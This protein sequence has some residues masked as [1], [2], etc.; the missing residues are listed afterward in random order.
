MAKKNKNSAESKNSTESKNR[1]ENE[2]STTTRTNTPPTYNLLEQ[3][4]I[5]VLRCDGSPD[6]IAPHQLTEGLCG[7]RKSPIMRLNSNRADFNAA[8]AQFLIGLYQT[9]FAPETEKEWRYDYQHPPTPDEL[10]KLFEQYK[11]FFWLDGDGKRF[12]QDKSAQEKGEKSVMNQLLLDAPDK[13]TSD[14]TKDHFIKKT[15]TQNMSREAVIPAIIAKQLHSPGVGTG[16]RQALRGSK[17]LTTLVQH[18]ASLWLSIWLNI[19]PMNVLSVRL[20]GKS[21][22]L[23]Y[24]N[25]FPWLEPPTSEKGEIITPEH[26]HILAVYWAMPESQWMNFNNESTRCD[27][28]G[29]E[30]HYCVST[31]YKRNHG[32]NYKGLW[33]HPLSPIQ[34]R[35][36]Q[37]LQTA[38]VPSTAIGYHDWL[39]LLQTVENKDKTTVKKPALVIDYLL[40][41]AKYLDSKETR[42][43]FVQQ[44]EHERKSSEPEHTIQTLSD[45]TVWTFGLDNDSAKINAWRDSQIPIIY[46]SGEY[47]NDFEL[48]IENMIASAEQL[49]S[50]LK[51]TFRKAASRKAAVEDIKDKHTLANAVEER[52]WRSTE[53]RFY[54]ELQKL[55]DELEKNNVQVLEHVK[56]A[57]NTY[58]RNQA[59]SLFLASLNPSYLR[60]H[61][62]QFAKG[63][64]TLKKLKQ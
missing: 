44:Q 17:F 22:N 12:M 15:T 51:S 6:W 53:A 16:Y 49:A 21:A 34:E 32:G 50:A 20:Q 27:I 5:P 25:V 2:N 59:E 52:F 37:S 54:Q 28:Y 13:S 10:K 60:M 4:W 19:I 35:T 55:K 26:T 57:W 42:W 63:I 43:Q 11:E 38:K 61:P 56:K 9:A 29:K 30:D 24:Q 45:I 36:A 58:I 48:A 1:T 41:T 7:D 46:I 33:I 23:G 18:Q 3:A 47:R 14:K 31:Y 62:K 39:G 40:N 64:K 8:I